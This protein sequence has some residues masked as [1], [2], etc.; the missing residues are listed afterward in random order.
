[1]ELV[2]LWW[3]RSKL[4]IFISMMLVNKII[5]EKKWIDIYAVKWHKDELHQRNVFL[6]VLWIIIR[7]W[8]GFAII[9]LHTSPLSI[10]D[11]RAALLLTLFL[12]QQVESS[13]T[14]LQ[15]RYLIRI[16]CFHTERSVVFWGFFFVQFWHFSFSPCCVLCIDVLFDLV[17]ALL[18]SPWSS[19]QA[20]NRWIMR[21]AQRSHRIHLL[22]VHT[23]RLQCVCV[24]A[25]G[26]VFCLIVCMCAL[27]AACSSS[28]RWAC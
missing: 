27:I 23:Y 8:L 4:H 15:L 9:C 2:G 28:L 18:C 17:A 22:G 12:F 6:I 7:S 11:V 25:R 1:M 13:W 21:A 20:L 10:K 26:S 19:N 14:R 3:V 24:C 5:F 16:V